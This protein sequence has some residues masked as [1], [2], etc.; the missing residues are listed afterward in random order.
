MMAPDG[1]ALKKLFLITGSAG[2]FVINIV[3]VMYEE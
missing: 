2:L 1:L 3:P